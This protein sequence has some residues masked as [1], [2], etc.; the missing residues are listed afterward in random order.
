MCVYVY[1]YMYMYMYTFRGRT[2]ITCL[3]GDASHKTLASVP[4]ACNVSLEKIDVDALVSGHR[5][6]QHPEQRVVR[7][8]RKEVLPRTRKKLL[9]QDR[10]LPRPILKI[11]Q[12]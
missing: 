9:E 7:P 10:P 6:Q 12:T 3:H 2:L 4:K 1:V 5:N 11:G 8:R